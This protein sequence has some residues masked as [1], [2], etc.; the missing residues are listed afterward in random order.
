MFNM[1]ISEKLIERDR[2]LKAEVP[3]CLLLMQVGAF[4]QVMD[5]DAH[6]VS[7]VTGLE[8]Q[9][10]GDVDAP[11]VVGGFPVSLPRRS[12]SHAPA[13]ERAEPPERGSERQAEVP[14]CPAR[15]CLC[16]HAHPMIRPILP[17]PLRRSILP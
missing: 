2:A 12:R 16:N 4:M 1:V 5:E 15:R 13:W 7:A 10:G 17:L 14:G 11:T 3:E 6:A 9:I 8:L